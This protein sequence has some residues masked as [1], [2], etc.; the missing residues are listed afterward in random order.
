MQTTM[1]GR[2]EDEIGTHDLVVEELALGTIA[3]RGDFLGALAGLHR[4]P[5]MRHGEMM[6][7]IERHRLWGRGSSSTDV[8]LLASSRVVPGAQLWTRDKRLAV[9]SAQVGVATLEG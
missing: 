5:S 3:R 4:F 1:R 7:V 6:T 2:N 9:A 8:H